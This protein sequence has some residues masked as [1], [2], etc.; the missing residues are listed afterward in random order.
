MRPVPERSLLDE[1]LITIKS[2]NFFFYAELLSDY[3]KVFRNTKLFELYYS[4]WV[5]KNPT[6]FIIHAEE[7]FPTTYDRVQE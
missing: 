4:P 5:Y 7:V 1:M 3:Y 6:W 2:W